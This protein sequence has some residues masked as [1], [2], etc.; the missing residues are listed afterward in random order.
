MRNEKLKQILSEKDLS[1]TCALPKSAP[2]SPRRKHG[3]RMRWSLSEDNAEIAHFMES[4][5]E[6]RDRYIDPRS[7]PLEVNLSAVVRTQLMEILEKSDDEDFKVEL[8]YIAEVM[9]LMEKAVVEI[10]R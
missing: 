1:Y 4:L 7:A 10:S 3:N 9:Q 5:I 8:E 6:L 2:V